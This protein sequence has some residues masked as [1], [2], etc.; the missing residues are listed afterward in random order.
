MKAYAQIG[1][2][3]NFFIVCSLLREVLNDVRNAQNCVNAKSRTQESFK[4]NIFF[5]R[6]DKLA[7]KLRNIIKVVDTK[8]L[9][10]RLQNS[11]LIDD[12]IDFYLSNTFMQQFRRKARK[13]FFPCIVLGKSVV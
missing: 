9:S 13:M 12:V 4:D 1:I 6:L 8:R 11:G 3:I 10:Q 5:L 7:C 2:G